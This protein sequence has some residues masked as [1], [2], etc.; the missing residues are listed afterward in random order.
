MENIFVDPRKPTEVVGLIDW[1]STE[2]APLFNN[3]QQPYF[4]DYDGPSIIGLERSRSPENLAQLN[5]ADQKEANALYLKRS[6]CALYKTLLYKQNPRLYRAVAFR[7]TPIFNLLLLAQNLL[8]DGEA[9]YLAQVLELETIWLELPGVRTRGAPPF[10]FRFSQEEKTEIETD[11]DGALR[12]MDAMRGVR[13]AL[14]DLFPERG[15]VR[16]DQYEEAL[17]ALRQVRDQVIETFASD[18]RNRILWQESWP[19]DD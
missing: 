18:E 8:I 4:L 10:P 17:D 5:P 7:E 6:L 9:T 12:G 19:F 15:I 14:V 13:E 16:N 11:V 1:Q 3:A 2:L